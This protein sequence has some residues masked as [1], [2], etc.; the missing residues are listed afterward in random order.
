MIICDRFV[1][2]TVAY[3]G[4]GRN[5]DLDMIRN[6]NKMATRGIEPDLTIIL[7]LPVEEGLARVKARSG[8]EQPDR[9]EQELADFHQRV[10]I[11]FLEIA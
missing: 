11:G 3:Q 2:S 8:E 1:D 10:R 7:D 5:I 4:Y 9:L 6:L